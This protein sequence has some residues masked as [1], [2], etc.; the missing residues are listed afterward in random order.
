LARKSIDGAALFV[1][2]PMD[3]K[4]LILLPAA[5]GFFASAQIVG[6]SFPG[7]K[8][9]ASNFATNCGSRDG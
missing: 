1:K 3:G 2:Q 9:F 4:R 5:Y 8:P 7:M 6:Y